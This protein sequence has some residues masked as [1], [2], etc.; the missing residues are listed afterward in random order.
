MMLLLSVL[1]T[2]SVWAQ[3][4]TYYNPTDAD[5]PTKTVV[6]P[7]QLSSWPGNGELSAGW[8]YVSGSVNIPYRFAVNGT[9]NIILVNGCR[10]T[11]SQGI[12][13]PEGSTLKIW[14]QKAGD[15][16]GR[17][18]AYQEGKNAAIGGEGGNDAYGKADD[19][20]NSGTIAI[21]G[22][23]I[24]VYGNIGGGDGGT[25]SSNENDSGIGGKGGNGTIIIY[26]GNIVVDSNMGGGK[27]GYGDGAVYSDECDDWG[28]PIVSYYNGGQGGDG[29]DGTITIYGGHVNVRG[30]MG[31]GDLGAGNE[32]FGSFGAGDVSLSWS[33]VSDMFAAQTY[34]GTVHLKKPFMDK[35]E[36][37]YYKGDYEDGIRGDERIINKWLYP[38]GTRYD[39]TIGGSY[40]PACLN[41]NKTR[42]MEGEE[43]KLTAVNGYKVSS[44]TVTDADVTDNHDGT[45][46]FTMPAKAVTVTPV[47]TRYYQ[48][49][50]S[51]NISFD[52]ANANDKMVQ[53]SKTYYR[54]GATVNF[55]VTVPDSY[56][57]QSL[58]V[59]D[60]DSQNVS[61]SANGTNAYTFTMPAKDVMMEAVTVRD[62]TGL[63]LI[64]GTAA[65][66]VTAG[67]DDGWVF[68]PQN[69]LDGKYSSTDDS[70]YSKWFVNDIYNYGE[71]SGCYVEFNTAAPVIPK[72]YTLISSN[73]PW[74]SP[75]CYPISWTI[76]AKA[77]D[78]D[79]WTTIATEFNNY[80][81]S[82][83]QAYHSYL[84]DFDNPG[85]NA[86]QY[87]R[88]EVTD[89]EGH[90]EW[91]DIGWY[92]YNWLELS[93]MQM[94]VRGET[95]AANENEGLYW[96]TYY[97]GT[98]GYRI[99]DENACAYTATLSGDALTLHKLGKVIPAGTAVIIVGGDN[100][101]SMTPSTADAE[102]TVSNNLHGVDE[103]T[104]TSTLGTGTFY[105]LGKQNSDF[106]FFQ[107]TAQYM[108]AH[109]AYLQVK[110]G[111]A[112]TKG[113]R[114]IV[115][116]DADG[117]RPLS[118]SP[119]G[120]RSVYDLS[121][122]LVNLSTRQL[123]NSLKKGIYIV[124]GKKILK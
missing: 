117:I 36:V 10:F 79:E 75:G 114:M 80:T 59:K 83:E 119:E 17:L 61:Y 22:G 89:V 38:Y 105:V 57:L 44:V 112:Q 21:Y 46:T 67:T 7:T 109:K 45:W 50:S 103:R 102:N 107:Y 23:D 5:N 104:E 100:S 42:A 55:Q 87:F 68:P 123:V 3:P 70:N 95:L 35:D 124:N 33:K 108:P 12:C 120:E 14:A 51:S 85:D 1:T 8:Y 76:Q 116:D 29:G 90:E 24:T 39:I 94:Y 77:S 15:G 26:D 34:R 118:G 78:G 62:L 18:T 53:N 69:L 113:L 27:G 37:V 63:T 106:G 19:G 58:T 52:V 74:L 40:D 93:E 73:E 60:E 32:T 110:S 96:T 98:E 97:N 111:A 20:E 16:C 121:G 81:M 65:F 47:S 71:S 86:Y 56:I 101:I 64:E 49:N 9:V 13:V 82:D 4:V 122:R 31:G 66:T 25:G 88:F 43:I 92:S 30:D 72:H 28:E 99:T 6:N 48:I 11:A 91:S 54:P 41:P 115:E 2:A 84:F